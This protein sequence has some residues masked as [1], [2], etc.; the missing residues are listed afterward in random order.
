MDRSFVPARST[1][2]APSSASGAASDLIEARISALIDSMTLAE[3]AGQMAQAEWGSITPDEVA[4]WAVGSVLSGGGGNPG[5]G[6]AA[7]WREHVDTYVEASRRSRLGIPILYGTDAV[8]GHNNVLGATIFPHHIGLG[9]AGDPTLV[10]RI[11]RAA[12]LETAATGAR[13]SFAPCLAIPLDVRWGRTYEGFSQDPATVTEL[14]VAAVEGW[15]GDDPGRDGVLACPKHFVGEGAMVWGTAGAHRHDWI[16]WWDGWGQAWQID[17]GDIRID[18]AELRRTHLAPFAAAVGAGALTVMAGYATWHGR[19]VHGHRGLLTDV[20]KG[21]LG[22][23]GFVVSDWMAVDQVDADPVRAVEISVNAGVDMVMVPFEYQR[24]IETVVGAVERGAIPLE[25]IDDAV[26]RI[27]RA[28]A[29]IGLLDGPGTADVSVDVVGCAEH[30]DLAREAAR[31]S[32]VALVERAA[33]PIRPD[34]SVFAAGLAIDD[35]GIAC[36]GWT[37]SWAGGTGAT[38]PG[39]TILDGLRSHRSVRYSADGD[40][41]GER[42]DVGVVTVHELP[43]VEGGGD[44]DDLRLPDDQAD[45]VRRVRSHVDRL[46]VLVVSGRPIVLDAV[47]DLADAVLAC[48]LPGSEADGIADLLLGRVPPSGRLPV[49]W[50]RHAGEVPPESTDRHHPAAWVVGHAAPGVASMSQTPVRPTSAHQES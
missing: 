33:L 46:V 49:H 48:W 45:L 43:Y 12:A 1:G 41:R 14:G 50:P 3:K 38:T 11:A 23:G 29:A 2:N 16:D 19:R 30:R 13:W 5:D 24:F 26:R 44:R 8:H 28:K 7:A 47:I 36:G 42:A 20:L 22:F 34:E 27:L 37:I 18:E 31:R 10:R 35:I 32:V 9:A 25:R 17:Q 40:F 4:E 21:D 15:H 6:S 39:R